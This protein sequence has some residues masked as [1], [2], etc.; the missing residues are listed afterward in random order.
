ME[1]LLSELRQKSSLLSQDPRPKITEH[2]TF[3]E[4]PLWLST[5]E[6]EKIEKWD[7]QG[8]P[9]LSQAVTHAQGL[10]QQDVVQADLSWNDNHQT[11]ILQLGQYED[12]NQQAQGLPHQFSVPIPQYWDD[13]LPTTTTNLGED[14]QMS[15]MQQQTSPIGLND[16]QAQMTNFDPYQPDI[17]AFAAPSQSANGGELHFNPLNPV[18]TPDHFNLHQPAFPASA[19][20][21]QYPSTSMNTV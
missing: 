7:S 1:D 9:L 16:Y 11:E 18:N 20:P 10:P 2:P 15:H 6:M 3:L 17:A 5:A 4:E 12:Q 21:F 14:A 13:G 8:S 19:M